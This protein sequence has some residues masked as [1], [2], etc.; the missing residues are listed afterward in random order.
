MSVFQFKYFSI[1]QAHSALKVGTD[2]MLL[3]ALIEPKN[4][5]HSLDI[6][7]GSGVLSLMVA[8]KNDQIRIIAIDVDSESLKDCRDNVIN[9]PW[10]D[11]ISVFQEDILRH[12]PEKKYD[13]IF[14]NPPFYK[15][16]LL[17]RDPRVAASKHA[18][19]LTFNRLFQKVSQILM[20]KGSFW[21]IFPGEYDYEIIETAL[22]YKLK[23]A[24]QV[25]IEG[26]PKRHTRTVFEFMHEPTA[27]TNTTLVVRD[28]N[29][30][31]SERYIELTKAYHD[32]TL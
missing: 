24:H 20:Q 30:N 7:T 18:N 26:V 22:L 23:V 8:Q 29:G 6:G 13:L 12:E 11:R 16:S 2:A 21:A 4:A 25:R 1:H 27:L 28:L 31:Y 32:R 3:G 5:I 15:N 10:A 19:Q 14:S 9:S 17:S